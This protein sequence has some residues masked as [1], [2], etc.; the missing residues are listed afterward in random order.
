MVG[1]RRMIPFWMTAYLSPMM[2]LR[3]L[4]QETLGNMAG[5][6]KS[7]IN[8]TSEDMLV[9]PNPNAQQSAKR[10]DLFDEDS[11]NRIIQYALLFRMLRG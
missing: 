3:R 8:A 5:L 7:V 10:G 9:N 6:E 4:Q 2:L 11:I 1:V